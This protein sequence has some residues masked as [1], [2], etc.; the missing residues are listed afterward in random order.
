MPFSLEES[1]APEKRLM[2]ANADLSGAQ[3]GPGSVSVRPVSGRLLV[4]LQPPQLSASCL[5]ALQ[6][7]DDSAGRNA[8]RSKKVDN[9]SHGG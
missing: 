8:F 4:V 2:G 3:Q 9:F 1:S 7:N 6:T 5:P